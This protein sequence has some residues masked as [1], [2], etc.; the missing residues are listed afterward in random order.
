MFTQKTPFARIGSALTLV[1]LTHIRR[2]GRSASADTEDIAET[3]IP[4]RPDGPSVVTTLTVAAT[5][6]I[7]SRKFC[8]SGPVID[9]RSRDRHPGLRLAGSGRCNAG[10]THL[11]RTAARWPQASS[12]ARDPAP[13]IPERPR[14]TQR[15]RN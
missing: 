9:R 7:A 15:N 13:P 3:V 8:R 2:I 10:G 4:N 11:R 14:T 1:L 5:R 12:S 6:L